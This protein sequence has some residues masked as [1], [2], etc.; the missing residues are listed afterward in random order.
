MAAA[1]VEVFVVGLFGGIISRAILASMGGL[2]NSPAEEVVFEAV[3]TAMGLSM[4]IAPIALV[5]GLAWGWRGTATS[6][7]MRVPGDI[8]WAAVFVC[9]VVWLLV[10]VGPQSHLAANVGYERELNDY[11]PRAAIDYLNSHNHTDFAASRPLPP[12]PFER[13]VFRELPEFVGQ[14]RAGDASWVREYFIGQL[15]LALLHYRP[16]RT[17]ESD[18]Q[19]M[20]P[21]DRRSS[22]KRHWERNGPGPA[23]LAQLLSGLREFPEGQSWIDRNEDVVAVWEVAARAAETMNENRWGK[24]D[25]QAA[26]WVQVKEIIRE[27]RGETVPDE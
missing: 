22:I 1:A 14:L 17:T 8:P 11:G 26:G 12:K 19:V 20:V 27:L 6:L 25:Q 23:E 2:R 24:A 3:S 21:P 4:W 5:V 16:R 10:S 15:D 18:W 13:G 7:P 9:G